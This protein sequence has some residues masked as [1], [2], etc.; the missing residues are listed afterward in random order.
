MNQTM[1]DER[2]RDFAAPTD[3]AT[4]GRLVFKRGASNLDIRFDP[5][6]SDLFRAHFDGPVPDVEVD[7]GVVSVRY[8]HLSP[9]E[10]AKFALL[11]GHH[12][13]EFTLNAGLPW[14][15]EVRGGVSRLEADL[16]GLPLVGI[17]I[18][19]GASRVELV[20]GQ[21]AGIVPIVVRGGVSNFRIQRPAGVG[22]RTMVRGGISK[23]ALDSMY[24]GAIGGA[25]RL[26][27]PVW[28][29][30]SGYEIEIA[31]GASHLTIEPLNGAPTRPA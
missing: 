4:S 11:G 17:E 13:A 7:R 15:L 5:G 16:S 31:G 8:H 21:A 14:Q 1:I 22:V 18:R 26:Q 3:G 10:W 30:A 6:M 20:L 12:A 23:L 28:N 24:L 27:T 25:S 29:D 19:G 2:V 9:A